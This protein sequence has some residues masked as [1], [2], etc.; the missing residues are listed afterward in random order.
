MKRGVARFILPNIFI[1]F[2]IIILC[3]IP[4][5]LHILHTHSLYL[6]EYNITHTYSGVLYYPLTSE[7][8][9]NRPV[10]F[11]KMIL[12]RNRILLEQVN[13]IGKIVVQFATGKYMTCWKTR[14]WCLKRPVT[15]C[16]PHFEIGQH[17]IPLSQ[18]CI[19]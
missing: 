6:K 8:D 18:K 2:L 5:F 11:L 9:E 7:L 16:H 13:N 19:V 15:F 4:Y 14:C 12:N 10:S 3:T 1:F 17:K